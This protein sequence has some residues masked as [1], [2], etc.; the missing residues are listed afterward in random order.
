ME[1]GNVDLEML[2]NKEIE[3]LKQV[4]KQNEIEYKKAQKNLK[5]IKNKLKLKTNAMEIWLGIKKTRK[6]NR[7]PKSDKS[8][9]NNPMSTTPP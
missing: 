5:D 6:Y 1:E 4:V 9:N 2:F 3:D 8:K 7:K